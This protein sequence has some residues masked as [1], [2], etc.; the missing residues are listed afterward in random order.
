MMLRAY[1]IFGLQAMFESR[2]VN[3]TVDEPKKIRNDFYPTNS[4]ACIRASSLKKYTC[5]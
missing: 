5:S 1:T 4:H 3:V 2:K